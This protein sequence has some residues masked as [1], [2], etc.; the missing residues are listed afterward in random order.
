MDDDPVAAL[1]IMLLFEFAPSLYS[2]GIH[3][4][5]VHLIP[6]RSSRL[7]LS[8]RPSLIAVRCRISLIALRFI[9][10]PVALRSAVR[11][12]SAAH[13]DQSNGTTTAMNRKCNQVGHSHGEH[14]WTRRGDCSGS[15]S[16]TAALPARPQPSPLCWQ[17]QRV[18][19]APALALHQTQHRSLIALADELT[20]QC[21]CV[22]DATVGLRAA[23]C[24]TS[25]RC[26][27]VR[28]ASKRWPTSRPH[29][30]RS[31]ASFISI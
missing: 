4:V 7:P 19:S 1:A 18:T 6:L 25:K 29:F 9:L 11:R 5:V 12:R 27:R 31:C 30:R 14:E 20:L 8:A 15:S 2:S 17:L 28:V 23:L 10:R 21:L 13:K 3:I 22:N 24:W 26:S 16:H